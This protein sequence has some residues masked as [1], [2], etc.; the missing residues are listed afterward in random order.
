MSILLILFLHIVLALF[1]EIASYEGPFQVQL[2]NSKQ[3]FLTDAILVFLLTFTSSIDSHKL[4]K[5]L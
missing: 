5:T 2:L 1:Q 4:G 3:E